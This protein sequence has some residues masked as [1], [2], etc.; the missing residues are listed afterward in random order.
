MRPYF[1]VQSCESD[2][3]KCYNTQ[4]EAEAK[5]CQLAEEYVGTVFVVAQ[6]IRAFQSSKLTL[7]LV[8]EEL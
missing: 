5:A 1:I 2:S 7:P 3:V 8:L 4:I 6:V